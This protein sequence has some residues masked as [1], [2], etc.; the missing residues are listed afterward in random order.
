MK[1]HRWHPIQEAEQTENEANLVPGLEVGKMKRGSGS[2]KTE[3][4][5]RMSSGE[6]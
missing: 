4:R 1:L 2:G 3:M 6:K 5:S